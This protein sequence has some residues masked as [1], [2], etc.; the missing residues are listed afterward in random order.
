MTLASFYDGSYLTPI[1]RD[2]F[3]QQMGHLQTKA[4]TVHLRR[5]GSRVEK[6][7]LNERN[8]TNL[9]GLPLPHLFQ[10]SQRLMPLPTVRTLR[11][12]YLG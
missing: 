10:L 5:S 3:L 7:H 11:I 4:F 12:P 8:F 9:T 6:L 2:W 1:L